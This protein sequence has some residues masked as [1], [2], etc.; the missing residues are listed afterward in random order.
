M[1][2]PPYPIRVITPEGV[3][4]VDDYGGGITHPPYVSVVLDDGRT[5]IGR[6]RVIQPE[7]E[8]AA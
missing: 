4:T 3:G 7:E 1:D 8:K 5:W 6:P 2:G